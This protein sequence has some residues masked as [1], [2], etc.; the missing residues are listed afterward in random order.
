MIGKLHGARLSN[1]I[2]LSNQ[3]YPT[4]P[5]NEQTP[6]NRWHAIAALNTLPPDR[7][8]R[9]EVEGRSLLL[10]WTNG[11]VFAIA[12][13]CPH[14]GAPLEQGWVSDGI[15]ECP[16]HHYRYNLK[17]GENLY[18]RNVYPADLPYLEADLTP[19]SCYPVLI[20]ENTIWI[21]I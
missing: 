17:T 19:L 8:Q 3:Q 9:V 15:L 20:Q 14:R 18:P 2:Y 1:P 21:F 10:I 12:S 7:L 4:Y 16:W 13:T 11:G 5:P 6:M